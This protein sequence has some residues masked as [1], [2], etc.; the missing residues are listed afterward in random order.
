MMTCGIEFNEAKKQIQDLQHDNIID[1]QHFGSK[2]VPGIWTKPI[3]DI[4]VVLKS[5][6]NIEAMT[7]AG[8]GDWGLQSNFLMIDLR[9]LT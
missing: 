3:L 6:A 2:A 5:F 9:I 1:I 7:P 4:A 8:Y